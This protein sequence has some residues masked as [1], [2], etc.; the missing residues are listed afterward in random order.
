VQDNLAREEVLQQLAILTEGMKFPTYNK[1]YMDTN[2]PM[3]YVPLPPTA[4]KQVTLCPECAESE[5]IPDGRCNYCQ[6]C[7]WKSCSV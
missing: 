5:I 6:S 7:G 3:R 1:T 4:T 2:V